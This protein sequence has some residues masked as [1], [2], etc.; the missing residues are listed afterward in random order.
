MNML[1]AMSNGVEYSIFAIEI[2][3]H[4]SSQSVG[5]KSCVTS[6]NCSKEQIGEQLAT[7]NKYGAPVVLFLN[8][9]YA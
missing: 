1:P 7:F 3:L 6:T 9:T 8:E 5:I 2:M 4:S